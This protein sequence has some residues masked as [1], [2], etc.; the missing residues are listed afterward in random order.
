MRVEY[1][2]KPIKRC[3]LF[4][5]DWFDDANPR[6]TRYSRLNCTYE[7]NYDRRYVKYDLFII[8]DVA[9]QVFYIS[10]PTDVPQKAHWWDALVNNSRVCP[11]KP[12][13]G[14]MVASI[15]QENVMN[16]THTISEAL[17]QHLGDNSH[18][19]EEMT[20]VSGTSSEEEEQVMLMQMKNRSGM[21]YKQTPKKIMLIYT[22]IL[23]KTI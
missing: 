23:V 9:F 15:F 3:V 21:I 22:T 4:R 7:D 12:N 5:C 1:L 16:T 8:A 11:H 19:L 20:V 17:P 10:Y 14:E 13:D 2:G 18:G 6:G